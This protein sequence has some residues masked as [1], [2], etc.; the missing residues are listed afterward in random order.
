M[1]AKLRALL[2]ADPLI[3]F[4]TAIMGTISLAVSLFDSSGRVQH[5]VARAWARM[6]LRIAGVQLE[7]EGLDKLAPGGCYVFAVNHRSFMDI[8]VV[9]ASIPAEFRFLANDYL[10]NVPFIGYHLRRA[11]HLPVTQ[12]NPRESLRTMTG[13]A[14]VVE[15]RGISVLLFPEGARTTGEMRPFRDG[16]AYIAI[17]AGVPLVPVS[18]SGM[19]QILPVG[20]VIVRGGRVRMRVGD[21]IPAADLTLRDR[22]A[23]T[24]RLYS[25]VCELLDW[26][27]HPAPAG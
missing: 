6:L 1:T 4:T 7:I 25:A 23:L 15:R 10:F 11:G 12:S 14:R 3:V 13:A 5:R 21:P 8:P 16:A 20:S 2:I 17:K 9:L 24:E 19:T 22:C 18:L 26:E 27:R